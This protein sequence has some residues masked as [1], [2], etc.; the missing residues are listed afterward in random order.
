MRK[1]IFIIFLLSFALNS[2]SDYESVDLPGDVPSTMK[3]TD[4]ASF[5]KKSS[6]KK[7]KGKLSSQDAK[8]YEK[9]IAYKI[10]LPG[11]SVEGPNFALDANDLNF[12]NYKLKFKIIAKP[13]IANNIIYL[14][15]NYANII[16]L[17][18]ATKKELW[19]TGL[20]YTEGN[21]KFISGSMIYRDNIIYVTY[22][23]NLV[24]AVN[25][26]SGYE[27]FRKKTNT[28]IDMRPVLYKE[29]LYLQSMNDSIE[30]IGAKYGNLIWRQP[31][32]QD[33]SLIS[34]LPNPIVYE[35][36]WLIS[37]NSLGSVV[38]NDLFD[39]KKLFEFELNFDDLEENKNY[40][41][42]VIN[43]TILNK[44]SL[45][46]LINNNYVVNYNIEK[47]SIIW[48]AKIATI[49]KITL[50]GNAIIAVTGSSKALALSS[51]N[52]DVIWSKDLLPENRVN[53][54]NITIATPPIVAAG[55]IFVA[56]NDCIYKLS[57]DNGEI[58]NKY[59][60][61]SYERTVEF[62]SYK[63]Q[64]V[65]F[66]DKTIYLLGDKK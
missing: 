49:Q 64:L 18:L 48:K 19:K 12:A 37:F 8:A 11:L 22:G 6:P 38:I 59:P 63:G 26:G 32:Q 3:N 56:T 50:C 58:L 21:K 14:L 31:N 61:N 10:I 47:K 57:I 40:K 23:D 60:L 1:F 17:D 44:N 42:N 30:S 25:A 51:N 16:A 20:N 24:A 4:I 13:I 66:T 52:G 39:G 43:Q 41:N 34:D 55:D 65:L 27:I 33:Q 46:I 45:Y 7:E 5:S 54:K 36:K 29:K 53:K 2:C 62:S 9:N 35:N 28:I 15:D